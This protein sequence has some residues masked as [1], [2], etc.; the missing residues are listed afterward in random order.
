MTDG[1]DL[2]FGYFVGFTGVVAG[3]GFAAGAAAVL[4]YQRAKLRKPTARPQYEP[5]DGDASRA[6]PES[7]IR[8]ASP[9]P[10]QA[11]LLLSRRVV[12]RGAVSE[13]RERF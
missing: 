13:P 8:A 2:G 4:V 5:V 1:R 11:A 12:R 6:A 9:Q 10:K 3:C 7:K